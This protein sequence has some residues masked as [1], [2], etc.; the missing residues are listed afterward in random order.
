MT[1][2]FAFGKLA[3]GSPVYA[4][5]GKTELVRARNLLADGPDC[6][7]YPNDVTAPDFGYSAEALAHGPC[8]DY[9]GASAKV[10]VLT[11]AFNVFVFMNLFN[12]INCR[13][14]S[15][16]D[17]NV[18]ERFGH[19]PAFLIVLV[20]AFVGHIL[21][22]QWCPLLLRTLPDNALTRSEWGGAIA[23]GASTLAI[24][25]LLKL[26]PKKWVEMLP[27]DRFGVDEDGAPTA[28]SY[29]ARV[30]KGYTDATGGS[31]ADLGVP[32]DGVDADKS[33]VKNGDEDRKA[34]DDENEG[35]SDNY[36]RASN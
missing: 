19:N 2:L 3:C 10:A 24:A 29:A 36:G 16:D 20:G 12:L 1:L 5:Y 34:I 14:V 11:Y 26:T 32:L 35:G 7:V 18:F 28:D 30:T 22:T 6:P 4:P 17:K 25:L 13:K 21:L 8:R 33:A 23:V 27:V 9:I 31:V 15:M